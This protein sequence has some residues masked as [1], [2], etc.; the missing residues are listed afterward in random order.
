MAKRVQ[1]L[2]V[3]FAVA[4]TYA[5]ESVEVREFVWFEAAAAFVLE[6]EALQLS[7]DDA[8]MDVTLF[9]VQT[10]LVCNIDRALGGRPYPTHYP[11]CA[12][13]YQSVFAADDSVTFRRVAA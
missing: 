5:D 2:P 7:G 8:P 3:Q 11:R 4:L 12:G 1:S 13:D 10:G 6:V 9:N